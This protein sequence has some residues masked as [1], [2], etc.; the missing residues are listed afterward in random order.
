M[1]KNC[2]IFKYSDKF[3][4][5]WNIVKSKFPQA[6]LR[7]SLQEAKGF[8]KPRIKGLMELTKNEKIRLKEE[9]PTLYVATF[10]CEFRTPRLIAAGVSPPFVPVSFGIWL[11][12]KTSWAI[13]FDAGRK[14]SR[15][16]TVLLSYATTGNPSSIENIRL[17]KGDFIRLK[18]WILAGGRSIRGQIKRIT[19]YDIEKDSTKFKQVVLS[20][21]RLEDSALFNDLLDSASAVANLTFS[22]PPLKSGSRPLICKINH[23]GGVTIYTPDLLD[24]EVSELIE[25]FEGLFENKA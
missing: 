1:I 14:L 3:R 10:S 18:N 4:D 2:I 21:V 12:K 17:E 20:S 11:R 16:A 7:K 23:W 15:A 9:K 13:S 25:I 22:T 5:N 6:T 19:M 8:V 24:S